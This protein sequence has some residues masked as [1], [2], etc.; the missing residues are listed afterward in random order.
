MGAGH[1]GQSSRW[2]SNR[3]RGC[4]PNP[5][6]SSL[7]PSPAHRQRRCC[8]RCPGDH[9][10]PELT[11]PSP[12]RSPSSTSA[13]IKKAS[14]GISPYVPDRLCGSGAIDIGNY[15]LAPWLENNWAVARPIPE[16]APVIRATLSCN[17][18]AV[19]LPQA[20]A[21][22]NASIPGGR[23]SPEAGLPCLNPGGST[24][25]AMVFFSRSDL[26]SGWPDPARN[27]TVGNRGD[28]KK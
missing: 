22:P 14:P 25:A 24:G 17:N 21:C 5:P 27:C 12:P 15:H 8:V 6:H 3:P 19:L 26:L 16:A 18:M 10:D 28:A 1:S 20:S 4:G 23:R 9:T 2:L 7:K 13:W 11:R